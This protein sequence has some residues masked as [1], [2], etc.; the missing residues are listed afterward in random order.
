MSPVDVVRIRAEFPGRPIEYYPTV[1]S[2]MTTAARCPPGAVVVA[3]EQTAGQGRHGHSWHSEAGAGL[4]FSIVLEPAPVL[5][6]AL[7]LAVQSALQDVAG[8]ACDLR[9]PN[10][11]MLGGKKLAG[12]LVQ[13]VDGKAIAGIGINL[14]HTAFPEELAS[15]ATSIKLHTAREPE[16]TGLVIALI[17]AI[18]TF[19]A[20]DQDAVLR[21]FTHASSY[22]V[23]RRVTVNQPGGVISGTTSGLDSS[24]FL[25]VRKDDGTDTLILAGGVR[26]AGS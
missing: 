5:T 2:T 11:V 14:T 25:I 10:D 3:G 24:G 17:H 20:E 18:E 6:L 8:I 21:L 9:W 26:A 12:I 4:Y 22:A 13:L 15:E 23:G 19:A 16:P 7:G 1:D